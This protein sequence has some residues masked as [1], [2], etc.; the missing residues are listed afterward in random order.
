MNFENFSKFLE[1]NDD[2]T[3]NMTSSVDLLAIS[4]KTMNSTT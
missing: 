2:E 1:I 4:P 3:A